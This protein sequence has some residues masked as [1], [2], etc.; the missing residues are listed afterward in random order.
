MIA[1]GV[2]DYT[3]AYDGSTDPTIGE[4]KIYKKQWDIY[5]EESGDLFTELKTRNCRMDDFNGI[6]GE[7]NS[8][9]PFYK[10]AKFSER[11]L[12]NFGKNLRCLEDSNDLNMWGNYDSSMASHVSIVFE[13]CVNQ[14][15]SDLNLQ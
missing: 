4:F 1:A 8:S 13:K 14:T 6:D 10:V 9:S 3:D 15:R 11:D 12:K 7:E 5:D 2:T